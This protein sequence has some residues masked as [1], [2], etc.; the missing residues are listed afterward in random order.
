[1]VRVC[2]KKV[3][4]VELV[5]FFEIVKKMSSEE[6]KNTTEEVEIPAKN[7]PDETPRNDFVARVM[8]AVEDHFLGKIM[9][10][11]IRDS[12]DYILKKETMKLADDVMRFWKVMGNRMQ[13]DESLA[14]G[15][16]VRLE[17]MQESFEAGWKEWRSGG[18]NREE[19]AYQAFVKTM[20]SPPE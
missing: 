2:I 5:L 3:V 16:P 9:T 13:E 11:V 12:T 7:W 14:D 1:M 15:E 17:K 6:N 10:R 20:T 18:D 4:T 8:A 19:L